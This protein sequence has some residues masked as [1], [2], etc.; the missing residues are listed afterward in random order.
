MDIHI[1][2]LAQKTTG[3][4]AAD[5]ALALDELDGDCESPLFEE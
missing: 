2:S 5:L 3:L 1:I 4:L